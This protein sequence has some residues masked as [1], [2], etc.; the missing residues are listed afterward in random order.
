MKAPREVLSDGA[1]WLA[2]AVLGTAVNIE[3]WPSIPL[4]VAVFTIW[5]GAS[6]LRR[7]GR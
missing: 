1:L 2:C 5:A 3:L 6:A 7:A 4:V